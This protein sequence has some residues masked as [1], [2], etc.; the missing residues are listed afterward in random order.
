MGAILLFLPAFRRGADVVDPVAD[1]ATSGVVDGVVGWVANL[2]VDR[3]VKSLVDRVVNW[4]VVGWV[5][6]WVANLLVD[7]VVKLLANRVV[8]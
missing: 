4:G 3:F 5:V 6:G 7:W 1:V 2:W 8:N